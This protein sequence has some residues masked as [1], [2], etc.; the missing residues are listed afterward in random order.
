MLGQTVLPG[1]WLTAPRRPGCRRHERGAARPAGCQAP[2]GLM[3]HRP[4][5]RRRGIPNYGFS[6]RVHG[7]RL[8]SPPILRQSQISRS[9]TRPF[10]ADP[11]AVRTVS[12]FAHPFVTI[13]LDFAVRVL[14]PQY[15]FSWRKIASKFG[16][17]SETSDFFERVADIGRNVCVPDFAPPT[18]HF[19]S[20]F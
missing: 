10:Q 11:L 14:V 9:P 1:G 20:H 5:S 8:G 12:L 3:A 17:D 19:P 16:G 7:R 6:Q 13:C 2:S 15:D 18:T 4:N